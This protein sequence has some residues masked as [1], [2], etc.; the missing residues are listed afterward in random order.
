MTTTDPH[1][2]AH[3]QLRAAMAAGDD[4]GAIRLRRVLRDMDARE[5]VA[6]DGWLLAP[7]DMGEH[8]PVCIAVRDR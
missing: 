5:P 7:L 4:L 2:T 8:G 1:D 6:A 3:G